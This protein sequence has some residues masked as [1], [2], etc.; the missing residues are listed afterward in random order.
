MDLYTIKYDENGNPTRAKYRIVALGNMDPVQW[1]KSQFYAPVLSLAEARLLVSIAIKHGVPL[2][3]GDVIQA[4]S[5]KPLPKDERYV[6]TPPHGCPTS[7]PN[8][9]W[10]LLCTLYGLKRS[11]R[12]W[13]DHAVMLLQKCGLKSCPQGPCIFQGTPIPGKPKLYLGLYVDDFVY[14]STDSTVEE[15]FKQQLSSITSVHFLGQVSHFLGIKFLWN[16]SQTGHLSVHMSQEAFSDH[17][18]DLVGLTHA[19]VS[20]NVTPY[21]S[22][23][24]IDSLPT[25]NQDSIAQRNLQTE[26][27]SYVGSLLWISQGTRP[28]LAT[29]TNM[30][31]KHQAH[32]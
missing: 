31:A 21:Q 25:Q 1:S 23:C 4:F 2:K 12:H 30:L 28:D 10:L 17:L 15:H 5:Q 19:S 16:R 27:R 32:P 20:T 11:P 26:Y 18:V 22:G 24:T 29:V 7:K 6:V 13:Y 14:F 8:T 9:Y 3:S